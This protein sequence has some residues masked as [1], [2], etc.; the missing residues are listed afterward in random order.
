MFTHDISLPH[1]GKQIIKKKN[2]PLLFESDS[3]SDIDYFQIN[4]NTKSN[5]LFY[6]Y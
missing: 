4:D 1:S 3:E 6:F 2:I 5:I